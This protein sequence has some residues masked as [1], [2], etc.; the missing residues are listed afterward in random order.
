MRARRRV[1]AV[2]ASVTVLTATACASSSDDGGGLASST[3]T[4]VAFEP[5]RPDARAAPTSISALVAEQGDEGEPGCAV[6]A[7]RGGEL[8]FEG[9]YGTADLVT[10][11]P[12]DATTTFDIASVSKQLTAAAVYLLAERGELQIDDDVR[13]HVPELPDYGAI[14]TLDDLVHH[15]SGI[16]DYTELLGAR[17]EDTDRTTTAQALA[18]LAAVPELGFEPGTAFEYSNSNYFLLGLVVEDVDGRTL[19]EFLAG[20]VFAPLGMEQSVVRDDADLV[21]PDGAEGYAADG[22]G[23]FEPD[24]TNWE[25]V[26]DGSVWTSV[27]DLQRWAANLGTFELGGAALHDDLLAPGAVTD[28]NG[29]GYGG[30]LTLGPGGELEHSGS[31]AGFVSELVVRPDEATSVAVLCNRDDADPYALV[32]QVLALL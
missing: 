15:T 9:G 23:G 8:I 5:N 25:Q 30:G 31:W 17:Y 16:A 28:E 24:T 32:E 29:L 27:R 11:E 2:L 1:V 3:S 13:D 26:G 7:V 12:I 21:V 14:V 22:A 18:A 10:D 6:S 20:E 19:A 4:V